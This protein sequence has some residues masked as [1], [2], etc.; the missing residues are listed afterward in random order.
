MQITILSLINSTATLAK[1]K[2]FF[3]I[4][5]DSQHNSHSVEHSWRHIHNQIYK[6]AVLNAKENKHDAWCTKLKCI[7]QSMN[8]SI[9]WSSN[10][11][12][13]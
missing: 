4:Y 5:M 8:L 2:I 9:N 6:K 3:Y 10:Q 12:V 7:N 1:K 13:V 11:S